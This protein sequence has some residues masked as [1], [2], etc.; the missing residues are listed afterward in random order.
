[1][2][3]PANTQ[4]KMLVH[5]SPD[6]QR[7]YG[8]IGAG[9]DQWGTKLSDD[10]AP[11][12]PPSTVILMCGSI[13]DLKRK[14]FSK[15]VFTTVLQLPAPRQFDTG[16]NPGKSSFYTAS[17]DYHGEEYAL[18][19]KLLWYGW[20]QAQQNYY[21]PN[22]YPPLPENC[23][24]P[25]Y[26][27]QVSTRDWA[28]TRGITARL[29]VVRDLKIKKTWEGRELNISWDSILYNS[30]KDSPD[31]IHKGNIAPS[32]M[33]AELDCT[34]H[35]L[36]APIPAIGSVC[37]IFATYCDPYYGYYP[38][39]GPYDLLYDEDKQPD[40]SEGVQD[41]AKEIKKERTPF[42]IEMLDDP[43][44]VPPEKRKLFSSLYYFHHKFVSSYGDAF[45]DHHEAFFGTPPD[46]S[47]P[48]HKYEEALALFWEGC[49]EARKY[50]E[51]DLARKKKDIAQKKDEEN[52][53]NDDSQATSS[54]LTDNSTL[55]PRSATKRPAPP[56][57]D[58][59]HVVDAGQQ[60]EGQ[61]VLTQENQQQQEQQQIT[62]SPLRLTGTKLQ[63]RQKI[64]QN[65]NA[66]NDMLV[67]LDEQ[68]SDEE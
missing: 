49:E 2:T 38:L 56:T 4:V 35:Q 47:P 43:K 5:V 26:Q 39:L 9:R 61:D 20:F 45:Y 1:M 53:D 63:K 36:H 48:L 29:G 51:Y 40:D 64:L 17:A 67:A 55:A 8:P 33:N 34:T 14:D 28:D 12:L 42:S 13:T 37:L 66:L 46:P 27:W 6:G 22:K 41:D 31:S 16:V 30:V 65:I 3:Y 54:T 57:T 24:D 59:D 10:K 25:A 11:Q 18:A 19:V 7:I 23:E 68:A 21:I 60:E 58:Q 52:N 62:T 32:D 15:F 44:L 50:R